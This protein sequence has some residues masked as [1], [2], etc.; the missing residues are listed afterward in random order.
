MARD[1]NATETGTQSNHSS[2]TCTAPTRARAPA[3]VSILN[4]GKGETSAQT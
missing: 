2:E 4:A 1:A 3:S